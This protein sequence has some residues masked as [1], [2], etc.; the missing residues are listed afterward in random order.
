MN[1]QKTLAF[2]AIGMMREPDHAMPAIHEHT[3]DGHMVEC[4]LLSAWFHAVV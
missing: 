3:S 2:G 4:V 1:E